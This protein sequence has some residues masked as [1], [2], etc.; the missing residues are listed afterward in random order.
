[1]WIGALNI[2]ERTIP[3]PRV[4]QLSV[5]K[6]SREGAFLMDCGTVMYLWIGR[7]CHPNFLSQVLGVP[8]YAA[9]PENLY[10]L[11]ELDTAE[12]QRTRAFIGW[13]RDQR[14]FFPS[15]HGEATASCPATALSTAA[16]ISWAAA[17]AAAASLSHAVQVSAEGLPNHSNHFVM[18]G[19]DVIT[20]RP[21]LRHPAVHS[22]VF[23]V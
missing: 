20:V 22:V 11:P 23:T 13:L 10:L 9:V 1:M 14:P 5:E 19:A 2:S 6:L 17:A 18:L 15:L 4:L 7:N 21:R 16:D 8:S 12:S 3:Q